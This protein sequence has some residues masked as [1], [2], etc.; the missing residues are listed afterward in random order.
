M[1]NIIDEL[2]YYAFCIGYDFLNKFFINSQYPEC[3]IVYDECMKLSKQ[4]MDSEKNKDTSKSGYECLVEWLKENEDRIK[5]EYEGK[6]EEI[7]NIKY[8]GIDQW[9]RPVYVDEKGIFYKDINLA[10]G[11]LALFTTANNNFYGEPDVQLDDEIKPNVV[12]RFS[13]IEKVNK[14]EMER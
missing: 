1:I 3:D 13:N 12:K 9:D 11:E 2:N 4:F 10:N 14:R 5:R 8:I 6:K 7:L